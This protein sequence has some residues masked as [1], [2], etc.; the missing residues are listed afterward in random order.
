VD[1]VDFDPFFWAN[2]EKM[3]EE[4]KR[5][6]TIFPYRGKTSL[7]SPLSPLSHPRRRS[8]AKADSHWIFRLSLA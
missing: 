5:G 7:L 1:L 6:L 3:S 8:P 4:R 2:A